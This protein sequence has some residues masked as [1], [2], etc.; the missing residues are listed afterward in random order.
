MNKEQFLVA[1]CNVC[2]AFQAFAM[3]TGVCPLAQDSIV[4]ERNEEHVEG[5]FSPSELKTAVALKYTG[6]GIA[7]VGAGL[8]QSGLSSAAVP[9]MVAGGLMSLLGLVSQDIQLIRLGWKDHKPSPRRHSKISLAAEK[10]ENLEEVVATGAVCYV[11]YADVWY[12]GKLEKHGRSKA[13]GSWYRVTFEHRGK[14][15]SAL[16]EEKNFSLQWPHEIEQ[17]E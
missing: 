10:R 5:S 6:V 1:F 8:V 13:R 9:L 7:A 12:E 3:T 17:E 2:F 15:K 16:F 11:R 4:F 14:E